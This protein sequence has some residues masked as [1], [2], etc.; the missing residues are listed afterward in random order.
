[1]KRPSWG[2]NRV[3]VQ[4]AGAGQ[5]NIYCQEEDYGDWQ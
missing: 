2:R 3:T 4:R 1:M 5:Y